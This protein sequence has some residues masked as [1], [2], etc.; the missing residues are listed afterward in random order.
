MDKTTYRGWKL[1]FE[2]LGSIG[3]GTLYVA[4]A[5]KKGEELVVSL[6]TNQL[7]PKLEL[8]SM[9]KEAIKRRALSEYEA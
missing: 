8:F 1:S 3:P 5:K 6:T 4:R 9:I 7:M 2:N